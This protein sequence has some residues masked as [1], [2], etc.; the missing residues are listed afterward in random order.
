[1]QGI[2]ARDI[3]ELTKFYASNKTCQNPEAC[4][5]NHKGQKNHSGNKPRVVMAWAYTTERI[6]D[7]LGGYL[8]R[9]V[10]MWMLNAAPEMALLRSCAVVQDDKPQRV[11]WVLRASFVQMHD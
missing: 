2:D 3:G 11:A 5:E 9:C 8:A 10:S 6:S 7:V 4:D 1:M